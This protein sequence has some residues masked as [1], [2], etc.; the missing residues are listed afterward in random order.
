MKYKYDLSRT[1]LRF[2]VPEKTG[3]MNDMNELFSDSEIK[4]MRETLTNRGGVGGE[5]GWGGV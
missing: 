1:S 4:R 3:R 2:S 5:G